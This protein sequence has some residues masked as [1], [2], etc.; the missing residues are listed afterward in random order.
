MIR[1]IERDGRRDD[2][3]LAGEICRA[4]VG[5][6]EFEDA[7]PGFLGEVTVLRQALFTTDGGEGVFSRETD[8]DLRTVEA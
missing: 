2:E 4:P 1:A 3:I 6:G 7:E 8:A 5:L